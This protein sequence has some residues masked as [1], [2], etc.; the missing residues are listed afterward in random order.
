MSP[1]MRGVGGVVITTSAWHPGDGVF[2]IKTWLSTSGTVESENHVNV[3]PVSL[4]DVKEPLRTTST[5]A[6]TTLSASIYRSA[7][8]KCPENGLTS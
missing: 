6:V 8:C 3:G 4:W 5:L 7:W 1:I 2:G